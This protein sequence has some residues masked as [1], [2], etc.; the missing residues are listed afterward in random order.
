M[1]EIAD[2]VRN[3]EHALRENVSP[4]GLIGV[5]LSGEIFKPKL[6]TGRERKTSA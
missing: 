5:L 6:T 3:W 1:L 4:L 2:V